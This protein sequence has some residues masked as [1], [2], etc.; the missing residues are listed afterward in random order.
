VVGFRFGVNSRCGFAGFGT[1]MVDDRLGGD[2]GAS[3]FVMPLVGFFMLT[4]CG[5]W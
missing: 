3:F 4:S 5:T 2:F 1:G